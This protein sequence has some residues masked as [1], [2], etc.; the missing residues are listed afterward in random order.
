MR[1]GILT[2]SY[3]DATYR[4]LAVTLARCLAL[5]APGTPRV[6]VT[7]QPDAPELH[8]HFDDVVPLRPELGDAF[9]QKLHLH[10]YSPFDR[11]LYIDSDSLVVEPIEHAWAAFRGRPFAVVGYEY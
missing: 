6:V 5:H 2:S 7:D 8:A 9:I 4:R 11:T 1:E 10:R 3:G